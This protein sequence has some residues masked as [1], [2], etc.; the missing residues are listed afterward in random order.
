MSNVD[1]DHWLHMPTVKVWQAC[2]L[3]MDI[4]PHECPLEGSRLET[5]RRVIDEDKFDKRLTLLVA[6]TFNT[7]NFPNAKLRNPNA[8]SEIHLNTFVDWAI[9]IVDWDISK[10]LETLV[11]TKEKVED[12]LYREDKPNGE[13]WKEH[14]K[15][16]PDPKHPWRT[17]ARYFARELVRD[18]STLLTKNSLLH[19][20]IV[21]S[22]ADV[23]IY[24][25]GGK[26][27]FDPQTI[28]K[29]FTKIKYD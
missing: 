5:W 29:A 23:G 6:H 2:A 18:D 15:G 24:K 7:D 22:L 25:R 28:R 4:D 3:S 14:R 12:K 8:S 17:V 27:P 13:P 21:A 16:D 9:N 20:K 19:N 11:T 10:E 26:K 1:W